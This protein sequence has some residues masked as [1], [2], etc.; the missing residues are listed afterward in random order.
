MKKII[1]SILSVC[2]IA[3]VAFAGYWGY[4]L[5]EDVIPCIPD[6]ENYENLSDRAAAA[7]LFAHRHGLNENYC[8][9]VDYSIPSGTPRLFVWSFAENKIIA[10][11]YVMHGAGG[12]S[13]DAKA[14]FSNR[15]GSNCSTLGRFKVTKLHGH[16]NKSGYRISGMDYDNKTALARGIM[17][18]RSIWVDVNC[19]RRYIPLNMR[20]CQGCF[21]VS[22]KGH[23]YLRNLIDSQDKNI[24]LW[25]F[26]EEKAEMNTQIACRRN[27]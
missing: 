6:T 1:N 26:C 27:D 2:V 9:F 4:K 3:V 18:H 22:S 17:I 13:T 21:T 5:Y 8:M 15:F 16:R 19:W 7:K 24:L 10:R 23:A 25:S 14:Q 12:G 11:T 20:A